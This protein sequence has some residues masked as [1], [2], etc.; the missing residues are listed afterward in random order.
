[1]DREWI[2]KACAEMDRAANLF[3][4]LGAAQLSAEARARVKEL[5]GRIPKAADVVAVRERILEERRQVLGL[6]KACQSREQLF[7][8]RVEIV[9]KEVGGGAV[10]V[11]EIDKEDNPKFVVVS[12]ELTAMKTA[13]DRRVQNALRDGEHGWLEGRKFDE[14][15][16][17][18]VVPIDMERRLAAAIWFAPRKLIHAELVHSFMEIAGE[19]A[20]LAAHQ[21]EEHRVTVDE[22]SKIRRLKSF[23]SL[24][25]LI[26]A[27][28]K[29][30]ELTEQILR[31]HSSDL[32]V[33]ITGESGTG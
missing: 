9:K 20:H 4:E 1:E 11:Y 29:M 8:E 3:E 2:I 6:I 30:S 16:F 12:G 24:P 23:K 7:K 25:E 15:I 22:N 32:T 27:S 33:L 19:M 31:I 18:D 17:L 21:E 5:S 26:Y 13:I 10:A 28:R 14:P